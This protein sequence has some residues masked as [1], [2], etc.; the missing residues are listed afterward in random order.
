MAGVV[1]VVGG[2]GQTEGAGWGANTEVA[3][4]QMKLRSCLLKE[5]AAQCT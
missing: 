5:E 2:Q 4:G 3:G 1:D